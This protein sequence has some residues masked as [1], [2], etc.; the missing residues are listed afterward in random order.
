[1]F[2]LYTYD[3]SFLHNI[4]TAYYYLYRA[5]ILKTRLIFLF[6]EE[7]FTVHWFAA[8]RHNPRRFLPNY[9]WHELCLRLQLR[10]ETHPRSPHYPGKCVSFSQRLALF[11]AFDFNIERSENETSTEIIRG[12]LLYL[13]KFHNVLFADVPLRANTYLELFI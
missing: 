1:M 3:S 10:S 7:E 9:V 2:A 8:H 5:T 4:K 12:F 13:R 6:A 11:H